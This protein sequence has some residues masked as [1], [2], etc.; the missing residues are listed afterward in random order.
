MERLPDR[1][2]AERTAATGISET[3]GGAGRLAATAAA[4]DGKTEDGTDGVDGKNTTTATA[5]RDRNGVELDVCDGTVGLAAVSKPAA[6][7]GS[8][9]SDTD[10]ISKRRE[11]PGTRHQ[12]QR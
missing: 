5:P 12:S 3:A 6:G 11:R 7:G 2:A 8:R 10:A 4:A 1:G 9:G